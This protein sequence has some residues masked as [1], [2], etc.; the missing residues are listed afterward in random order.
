MNQTRAQQLL[1]EL[2]GKAV[3]GWEVVKILGFGNSAVVLEVR[4]KGETAA[5][6]VFDPEIIDKYGK[7]IQIERVERERSLIGKSHPNLVGI[8]DAGECKET[9]Q[10]YVVMERVEAKTLADH[11]KDIPRANIPILLKQLVSACRFLEDLGLVHRDIKPQ[12]ISI[13]DEMTELKLLDFGVICPFLAPDLTDQNSRPF[14]GT[15]R[16]SSPE[17]LLRDEDKSELGYRAITFYQIGAVLHDLLMKYPIFEQF[18]TPFLVLAKAI[19][20]E[21]PYIEALD[22]N[23]DLVLLAKNCLLKDPK[24]RLEFLKWNDFDISEDSSQK[25]EAIRNRVNQRC[26]LAA[27]S[28]KSSPPKQRIFEEEHLFRMLKS[29]IRSECAGKPNFSRMVIID[30]IPLVSFSVSF[31]ADD[32]MALKNCLY[33]HIRGELIGDTEKSAKVFAG[34]GLCDSVDD[35]ITPLKEAC[36]F[37]GFVDSSILRDKLVTYLYLCLDTAQ[38]TQLNPPSD[39]FDELNMQIT[40]S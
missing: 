16:Y 22:V 13:N 10:L 5:L 21:I 23:P 33:I 19:E 17:F 18:S 31:D 7:E 37:C 40:K 35:S 24:Q 14:I 2:A 39:L 20:N 1:K 8:I 27:G 6:K 25:I 38:Q 4:G 34:V 12:N 30:T 36:I 29:I 26:V 3:A 9:E 28:S 15:L 32:N 11:V